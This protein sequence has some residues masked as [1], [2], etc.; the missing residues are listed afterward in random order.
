[1]EE[2]K[3][4]NKAS[5]DI[6]LCDMMR[7][8][9]SNTVE[10]EAINI[11]VVKEQ[12]CD[13]VLVGENLKY[14]VKIINECGPVV[15]DLLFKDTF[16]ECTKLV[17]GSFTVDDHPETPDVHENTLSF[18]IDKLES[19]DIITITFE[20]KVTE[21]CCRRSCPEPEKS[22]TPITRTT[23]SRFERVIVGTGVRGAT[24]YATFP[25]SVVRSAVVNLLGAWLIAV[26]GSLSA[27]NVITVV[28]VEPGKAPSD[29]VFVTVF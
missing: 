2:N 25:G 24:V 7:T 29:P 21:E 27:G 19:C 18:W 17:E 11:K 1:M 9:D 12:S 8:I 26:P 20:V 15:H 13:K 23:I 5:V 3:I 6:E 10:A 22:R 16:D 14:T 4:I 28:Q